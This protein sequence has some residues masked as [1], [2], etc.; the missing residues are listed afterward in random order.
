[1]I[2]RDAEL[3]DL[4]PDDV[5]SALEI[6]AYEKIGRWTRNN[7]VRAENPNYNAAAKK[8]AKGR[9]DRC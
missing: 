9:Q 5:G 3:G 6:L 1:M 4:L 8:I 7:W 2:A